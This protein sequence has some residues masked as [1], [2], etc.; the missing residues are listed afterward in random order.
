MKNKIIFYVRKRKKGLAII[1]RGDFLKKKK[2]KNETKQPTMTAAG[3]KNQSLRRVGFG[4]GLLSLTPKLLN[5]F[6][7]IKN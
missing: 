6:K 1:K 3:W 4:T 2:I 5:P 7:S